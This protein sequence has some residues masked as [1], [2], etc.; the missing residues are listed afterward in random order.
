VANEVIKTASRCYDTKITVA[1]SNNSPR[2]VVSL[3]WV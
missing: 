1:A 2:V 3:I